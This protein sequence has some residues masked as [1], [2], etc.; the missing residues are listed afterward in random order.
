MQLIYRRI[1]E[2]T[3][4]SIQD[5]KLRKDVSTFYRE[6]FKEGC[7]FFAESFQLHVNA[8]TEDAPPDM[9]VFTASLEGLML[10]LDIIDDIQ[11]HDNEESVWA[12]KGVAISLNVA[13]SLMTVTSLKLSKHS[14][15]PEMSH[16]VLEYLSQSIEGQHQDLY[17]NYENVAQYLQLVKMKSGSLV[18]LTNRLGA[19]LAG[20]KESHLV[21]DYSYDLGIAAQIE[22]DIKDVF[23]FEE[24]SDWKLKKKT[25]PILYL[26]NPAI[27]EG[28]TVRDYFAG[29]LAFMELQNQKQKLTDTIKQSGALNY[30][31]AQKI[32]YE[33]RARNKIENLPIA[34]QKIELLKKNLLH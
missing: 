12:T 5:P 25:L 23:K 7:S 34:K 28:E 33:Q 16:I 4:D 15:H 10:A 3:L 14:V 17:G 31:V 18:A 13:I 30:A 24:K 8:F 22:N 6:K 21:E 1:E 29:K 19:M 26:L 9:E 27:V 32:L 20:F 2:I 11:D